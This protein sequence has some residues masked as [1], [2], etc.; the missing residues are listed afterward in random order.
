[1]LATAVLSASLSL[2]TGCEQATIPPPPVTLPGLSPSRQLVRVS[3]AL[4]GTHPSVEELTQVQAAPASL[5][6]LVDGYLQDSRF[7]EVIRDIHDEALLVRT[8]F[9]YYPAGFPAV[10]ALEGE[11]LFH[12]NRSLQEA[13]LRLAE[14]VV[15]NDLPYSDILTADYFIA[16]HTVATVWGSTDYAPGGADWQVVHW[17]DGRPTAGVLTD[18]MLFS[19]H[20]STIANANRGRANAMTRALLC[21]DYLALDIGISSLAELAAAGPLNDSIAENESCQMCHKTLDPIA[22]FFKDHYPL[23][24]P[25]VLAEYPFPAYLPGGFGTLDFA[26]PALW[27]QPGDDIRDLGEMMAADTMFASCAARRFYAHFHQLNVRDVPAE[28]VQ[29]FRSVLVAS[30]LNARALARAIVLDDDFLMAAPSPAATSQRWVLRTRPRQ[31]DNLVLDLTGYRWESILDVQGHGTVPLLRDTFMGFETVAGG[32]DGLVVTEPSHAFTG[33]SQLLTRRL[34]QRAA[35]YAV[36]NDFA[37][38]ATENRK[39]LKFIEPDELAAETLR[40]QF[41]WLHARLYGELLPEDDA[42]IDE[43]LALFHAALAIAPD[44]RAAWRTTLTAMLQDIRI[45]SY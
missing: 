18:P 26:E 10:G 16:N 2:T 8:D 14:H 28:R 22:A 31:L 20:S 1:M 23:Y 13:S 32:I 19:R 38:P 6:T 41:S 40:Q 25:S 5:A 34:A 11:G 30:S 37:E 21:F 29:H 7:G 12:L 33:P 27:E 45:A 3:M 39:L 4:R 43:S 9:A 36:E 42:L 44:G 24:L 35:G 17:T 15:M